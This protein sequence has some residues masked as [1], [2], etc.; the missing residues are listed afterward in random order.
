[1]STMLE[2]V[3][4]SGEK[5]KNQKEEDN[6]LQMWTTRVVGILIRRMDDMIEVEITI[7]DMVNWTDWGIIKFQE[8]TF[9]VSATRNEEFTPWFL[10]AWTK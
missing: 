4:C 5:V 9:E 2:E 10:P 6:E 8:L 1:M 7:T 3:V